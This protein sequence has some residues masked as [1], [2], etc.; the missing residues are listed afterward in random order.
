MHNK[1]K[2]KT[3]HE[4]YSL[5]IGW[6]HSKPKNILM[7]DSKKVPWGKGEKNLENRSEKNLKLNTIKQLKQLL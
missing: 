2:S 5:N 1:K 3:I 6:P 7:I 4:K